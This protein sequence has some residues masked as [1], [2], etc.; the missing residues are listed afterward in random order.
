MKVNC[1]IQI[2]MDTEREPAIMVTQLPTSHIPRSR[3][4]SDVFEIKDHMIMLLNAL[5]ASI[6]QCEKQKLYKP[7]QGLRLVHQNLDRIC[8]QADTTVEFQRVDEYGNATDQ[9]K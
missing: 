1:V 6:L 7:G 5:A 9:L 2:D 3:P 4:P 8:M